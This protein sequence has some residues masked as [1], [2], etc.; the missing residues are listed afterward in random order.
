LGFNGSGQGIL[1]GIYINNDQPKPRIP[2]HHLGQHQS[3]MYV[4]RVWRTIDLREKINHPL[5]YHYADSSL[6]LFE[7]LKA[8]I[9]SQR[10]K[11]FTGDSSYN[12]DDPGIYLN[13][14]TSADS[15]LSYTDFFTRKDYFPRVIF[16]G[17]HPNKTIIDS[18]II[19]ITWEDISAYQLVEDWYFDKERSI[20][21]VQLIGIAPTI[22]TETGYSPLFWIFYPEVE[23]ALTKNFIR[24]HPDAYPESF[25]TIFWKRKF[26]SY[27][28]KEVATMQVEKTDFTDILTAGLE[29]NSVTIK[30]DN[31]EKEI[32]TM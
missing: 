29:F 26:N 28:Y 25:S 30:I 27:V 15:T 14:R 11:L 20:L 23:M 9:I 2:Y 7:I 19:Q 24:K 21:D 22:L 1:D 8:E 18:S 10:T 12:F 4:K 16:E 32:W 31:L 5:Y 17:Q 3:K 6:G 13:Q